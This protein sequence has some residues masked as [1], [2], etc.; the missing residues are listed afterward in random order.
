MVEIKGHVGAVLRISWSESTSRL[1]A[2]RS[3]HVHKFIK[4]A[5]LITNPPTHIST[6]NLK[7]RRSRGLVPDWSNGGLH[8]HSPPFLDHVVSFVFLSL[9]AP[10][11]EK[12]ASTS[13]GLQKKKKDHIIPLLLRWC[14][15][16]LQTCWSQKSVPARSGSEAGSRAPGTPQTRGRADLPGVC[17][18]GNFFF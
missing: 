13:S 5:E 16:S 8:R 2:V 9:Q 18:N 7:E 4:A 3:F 10:N 11:T 6:V 17:Q 14:F 1:L 15:C 12:Q